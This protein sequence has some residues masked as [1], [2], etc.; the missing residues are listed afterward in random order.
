MVY[1][2]G[3]FEWDAVKS[4]QNAIKHGIPFETATRLWEFPVLTLSSKESSEI[5]QLVIGVIDGVFWTAITTMR[6][7]RIRI[8]SVRR[9]RNEEKALYERNDR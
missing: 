4:R 5:R 6:E 3:I 1:F 2:R 7:S 8:I 9:S